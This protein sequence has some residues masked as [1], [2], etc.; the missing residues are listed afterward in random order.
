MNWIIAS[1][2]MF[3]SSVV[4]YLF[5]RLA[6]NL[7]I[8]NAL[9]NLA[10]FLIPTIIYLGISAQQLESLKVTPYQMFVIVFMAIFFSYLGNKLSLKSIELA[11]NPGF[12]L[13]ISKSYVV[14]TTIAA[15]FL[16]NASLSIRTAIAIALIVAGSAL[17]MVEKNKN[18]KKEKNEL[19]WF[20]LAIGAF[21]CWGMLALVSKY[22]LD[23]GVSILSRLIYSMVIVSSIIALEIYQKKVSLKLTKKQF[24]TLIVIGVFGAGFN[25]FMQLAYQ[26]TPNVGFVNALN[27]SSIAAVTLLSGFIFKDELNLKKLLGVVTVVG[28]MILLVLT[29]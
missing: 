15:V 9:K 20:W 1:S 18:D 11:P 19:T 25:Y 16:F 5:V 26:L 7:K 6:N 29:K 22:L 10:M 4:S 27:A 8:D 13:V 17:I 28:G 21:F 23:L 2:L 12:S 14:F 3:L 24:L